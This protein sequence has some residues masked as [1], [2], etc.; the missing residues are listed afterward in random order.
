MEGEIMKR[1]WKMAHK[2]TRVIAK[3]QFGWDGE[4]WV[5]VGGRES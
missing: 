5:R 2:G 1:N 3:I 4:K